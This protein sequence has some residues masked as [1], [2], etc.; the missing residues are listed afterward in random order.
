LKVA[1]LTPEK[2]SSLYHGEQLQ[3]LGHYWGDREAKITLRGKVAGNDIEYKTAFSMP[4]QSDLNP[5]LERI[6]AYATIENLQAKMDYLGADQDTED[7][8]TDL[9]VEYG[10]VTDFTS[11]IVVR[12]EVFAAQGIRRSNRDRVATERVAQ[13]TRAQQAPQPRRAD[14]QK[15]MYQKK[16][17]RTGGGGSG[18]G[19]AGVP[20]VLALSGLLLLRRRKQKLS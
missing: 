13:Q 2:I 5:E 19:A 15:P 10:L 17:P 1:D 11:M 14:T 6:W 4:I 16:R 12:D 8:I 9:A 3:V 18:G 20:M 7:A